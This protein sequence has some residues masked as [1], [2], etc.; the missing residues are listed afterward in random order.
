MNTKSLHTRLKMAL[1]LHSRESGFAMVI[2]VSLGLIMIL[3]G[4]TM[5]MRSQGDQITASQQKATDQALAAAEKGVA[6]YQQLINTNRMLSR[7]D[8]CGLTNPD[9]AT[10]PAGTSCSNT[11]A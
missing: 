11:T 1:L 7:Y 6:F 8:D 10:Q 4:L 3:V 2:A 5:T 9:R